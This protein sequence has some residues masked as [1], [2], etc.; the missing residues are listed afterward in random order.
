MNSTTTHDVEQF[1][2]GIAQADLD[3]L[4]ERLGRTRWPSSLPG[5]AWERGVPVR[6]LRELA[7]YWRDGYDWRAQEARLN[8]YPQY[9]TRIDG[10]KIYFMHVKSPNQAPRRC[11]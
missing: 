6:Y 3:G 11:C 4:A 9:T 1:R 7:A 10:Q 5:A 2:I 8:A